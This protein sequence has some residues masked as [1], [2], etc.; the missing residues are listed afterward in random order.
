MLRSGDL[1]GS[2]DISEDGVAWRAMTSQRELNGVLNDLAAAA[3]ALAYGQVPL[4]EGDAELDLGLDPEPSAPP[5]K[6]KAPAPSSV[7]ELMGSLELDYEGYR[8]PEVQTAKKPRSG[9]EI[10]M[11]LP[12]EL[13]VGEVPEDPPVWITYRRPILGF[14]GAAA[15]VMLGVVTHFFT[16][17]GA[18]GVP[19]LVHMLTYQPPPPP[20]PA[21]PPPPP[22]LADLEQI[23]ALVQTASYE[24]F[25]SA[26]ATLEQA[27]PSV[28]AN[29]VALAKARVLASLAYGTENFPLPPVREAVAA[30]ASVD[31]AEPRVEREKAKARLGLAVLEGESA[32]V[33]EELQRSSET[34]PDDPEFSYLHGAALAAL[35]RPKDALA[36]YDRALLARPTHSGSLRAIAVLLSKTSPDDAV[37]YFEKAIAANPSD[38]RSA[39]DLAGLHEAAHRAGHRRRALLAM[40]RAASEGLVP[41]QRADAVL[42]AVEAF[43]SVGRLADVADL[44]AE[45][46]RLAPASARAVALLSVAEA[47]ANRAEAST[48]GLDRLLARDPKNPVLLTAR[49]RVYRAAEEV[50]KALLDLEAA[51]SHGGDVAT[52]MELARTNLDV[53]KTADARRV[54]DAAVKLPGGAVA[55]VEIAR[56][57]LDRGLVD[58][59][60]TEAQ[61]AV[62]A[63]ETLASAHTILGEVLERRGQP[64]PAR[65]SFNRALAL[66]DEAPGAQLGVASALAALAERSPNPARSEA[67][68][69]AIPLYF[70]ALIQRPNDPKVLFE[71]GRVLELQGDLAGALSLYARA[72]E[73]DEKDVRP[74][75]KMVAAY[76]RP[77][78]VDVERARRSLRSAQDIELASG[79]KRASVRFWES[80]LAFEREDWAGAVSAMRQATELEPSNAEFLM[81]LGQALERDGSLY[82]AVNAYQKALRV[83]SRLAEAHRALGL[84][85]M[86]LHRFEAAREH[87]DTYRRFAPEDT[88]VWSDIGDTYSR[89]NKDEE[90]LAAF[91]KALRANPKDRVAL[92]QSGLIASRRG[93]ER[94]AQGFFRRVTR[95]EPDLAEPWCLLGLSLGQRR[96]NPEAKMALNRC[97]ELPRGPPDLVQSARDL[98]DR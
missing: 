4:A 43:E 35:E 34:Y 75:L 60:L 87:F 85:S 53:G 61:A 67:L 42:A 14:L 7:D 82:E 95:A 38:A 89:Q 93:R 73:I 2:E 49:A 16:P 24:S 28:P 39:R 81:A 33:L 31:A 37:A 78:S 12:E 52:L 77:G 10:K 51:R 57:A 11:E 1:S 63:D 18:F 90:A 20:P 9:S 47:E 5:P 54:L 40:A 83:N 36:A 62:A 46:A 41:E 65:E 66:D 96:M 48:R 58:E 71:Y 74:H 56:L 86:E 94:E 3:D 84:A 25:R 8:A 13:E 79:L 44:A 64:E 69:R 80:R 19:A 29:A 98:L 6:A 59:A 91:S 92:L 21:P 22:R 70:D 32:A 26:V 76:L 45:A 97:L 88:S 17:Y 55:R 30:L 68:G 23:E 50:A 72:A 27:G 15:V